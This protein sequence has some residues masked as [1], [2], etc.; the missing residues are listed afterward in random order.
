MKVLQEYI[1]ECDGDFTV[2]RKILPLHRYTV[3]LADS[4][5][6]VK[7]EIFTVVKIQITVWVVTCS[8]AVEYQYFL[9][10]V[11]MHLQ[12]CVGSK[13]RRPLLRW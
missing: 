10:N 8:V 4:D 6:D 12:H 3:V 2:E 1:G 7:L 11:G 9:Q 13:C 5:H